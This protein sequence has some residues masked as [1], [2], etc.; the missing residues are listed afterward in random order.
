MSSRADQKAEARAAREA[1]DAEAAQTARRRKRLLTFGG[2]LAAAAVIIVAV[3]LITGGGDPEPEPEETVAMFEGIPQDGAWLGD[4]DAPVVVEEYADLQCPF[5]KQFAL[6]N[7]EPIIRDFV[8]TG[9]VRLRLRMVSI[10][11][12]ESE[13]AA[14]VFGAARQQDKGWQFAEAFFAEQGVEGSG[15]VDEE[16]LRERAEEAGLDVDKALADADSDVV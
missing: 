10:L 13:T 16:F 15:Y 5:C 14:G 9:D 11:G 4:P 2:L 6:E 7:L 1:A 3:V 8:R 12:P